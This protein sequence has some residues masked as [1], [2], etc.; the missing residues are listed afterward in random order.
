MGKRWKEYSLHKRCHPQMLPTTPIYPPNVNEVHHHQHLSL[1][2][3]LWLPSKPAS[4]PPWRSVP[5]IG[6]MAPFQA[7]WTGHSWW[8]TQNA[9]GYLFEATPLGKAEAI[10][11]PSQMQA[12][13][14]QLESKYWFKSRRK[15]FW[16]CNDAWS[17]W[18]T[19][20]TVRNLIEL[21]R[22]FADYGSTDQILSL[23]T[24][25]GCHSSPIVKP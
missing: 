9:F 5:T 12:W 1:R 15:P 21:V 25:Y 4:N 16:T 7:T 6:E 24:P 23:R 17:T 11:K 13:M 20:Y 19:T 22:L 10:S 3:L 14:C 2:T 8:E 18:Q